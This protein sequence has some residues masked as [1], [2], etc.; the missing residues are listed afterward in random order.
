MIFVKGLQALE[1]LFTLDC[2]LLN[3][4]AK[5][6]DRIMG[7][8]FFIIAVKIRQGIGAVTTINQFL[9]FIDDGRSKMLGCLAQDG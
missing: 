5:Y 3:K 2:K 8:R 6:V 7:R 9:R 1:C 4:R